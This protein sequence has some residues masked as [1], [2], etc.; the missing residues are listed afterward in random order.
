MPAW[1]GCRHSY[2][3]IALNQ[4]IMKY[5]NKILLGAL[6]VGALS[7]CTDDSMLPYDVG[8]KPE[9]LSQYEYLNNYDV[10]KSYVDR[11]ENP[12]FKLGIALAATDYINGDQVYSLACSNF[13]EMTAGN[14][15]KYASIV[16]DDGTMNFSTVTSFI[17][18]ARQA[19]MTIYGHTLAWHSQ[20]NLNYLNGLIADRE[21]ETEPAEPV[22][23][24]DG[25]F[26]YAVMGSY[27]YWSQKPEGS[28]ASIT[29]SD[30]GYLTITN[31]EF[32]TNNWDFQ[33]HIAD[34]INWVPGTDYTINM[35]IRSSVETS[36]TMAAG[37]WSANPGLSVA[38]TPEWTELE[39]PVSPGA[40]GSGF[41]MF[42]SGNFVGTIEVQWLK[43]SH[44]ETPAATRWIN[45]VTNGDAEG[46]D[47]SC[48]FATE[49]G[50]GG[51]N[52]CT[53][54]EAGTGAD[55]VGHAFVVHSADNPA[56]TYDTQFFVKASQQLVAGTNYRFSM[57]YK[58]DK[59]ANSETQ[60]HNNPG[61]Y[62]HYAMLPSN[63]SF[64]T[65]WQDMEVTGT[66]SAEQAGESGMNTIAFNL[67]VLGEANTYYF[68][69]IAFEIEG[70]GDKE[71]LTPEE[72]KDTLTWAMDNWI[73]GM[74][75]ACGGYVTTWEAANE[76][77]SGADTDGDGWYDL[78][79]ATNG[80]PE[81]NFYWQ[82]YLGN[83]DYVP[84][85]TKAAEKYFAEYGGNP[86]D[87]KLFVN[88][89]NLESLRDGN[90]KLK[91]LIHWIEVWEAN[92]AKI[93]GIGT[94]MHVSYILNEADQKAQEDAIVNM[95]ELMAA[96]GKL[97]KISELDMGIVEKAFGEGIKTENVTFDQQLKMA[98]FYQF[99][100]EKYFEIIPAAQR[101]GITQWCITDSPAESGWR[102]GEPVGLWDLN[103]SRK[104]AYGGFANGLAGEV[105]A[106]PSA[107][108]SNE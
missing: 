83:E 61:G 103:Y 80:D 19:G 37:T 5:T 74:M 46:D 77:V 43:V 86:A 11:T 10:L 99:I 64:T 41:V 92:G 70:E 4:K 48:F 56:N 96:T 97:I 12:N 68:D 39:I 7:G 100:I 57:K 88:D 98:E 101:Y 67:A 90:Q 76:T 79:S 49:P 105:I 59:A 23:V 72:K 78:Q 2:K 8:A 30:K 42:Q 102:G 28:E 1:A 32:I 17:D 9:S 55:G 16:S 93:D 58:A 18:A 6:A 22:E 54:G 63:P 60:A 94:Q 81:T 13:D 40:E 50:V 20:Q 44:L 15:M 53:I 66:I 84:I 52:P 82:D 51:P 108:V 27:Q 25:N 73:K 87:L 26:N 89:Y 38:L 62:I 45:L 36:I 21:I 65:E 107:S 33:Y 75:E 71:P 95:F 34:G 85:V 69:D 24:E 31:P 29:I 35:M 47:V 106:E 104:P 91:S 14:E 3:L